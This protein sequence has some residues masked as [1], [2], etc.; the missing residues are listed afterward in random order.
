LLGGGEFVGVV[1][2]LVFGAPLGGFAEA[3]FDD[4][5]VVA[6]EFA[7]DV[8]FGEAQWEDAQAH[9]FFRAV[10]AE[11]VE[12]AATEGDFVV[13]GLNHVGRVKGEE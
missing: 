10:V 8:G 9:G 6:L 5:L 3:Q 1:G 13:G 11:R 2:V 4:A 7:V 12:G